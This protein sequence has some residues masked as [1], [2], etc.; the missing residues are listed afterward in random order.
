MN[1]EIDLTKVNNLL[2]NI[3]KEIKEY[4]R[5]VDSFFKELIATSNLVN[6]SSQEYKK[7]IESKLVEYTNFSETFKKFI[8]TTRYSINELESI[9]I[10]NNLE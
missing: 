6:K 9:V 1:S 8:N 5:N 4:D 7:E 3:D 2:S 10:N